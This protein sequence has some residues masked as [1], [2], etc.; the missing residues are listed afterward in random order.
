MTQISFSFETQSSA[1][2]ERATDPPI[3]SVSQLNRQIREQLEGQFSM[4][5]IRGEISNFKAHTSGHLYFSLK[6]AKAQ[7]SAIMFRGFNSKLKFRP[8]DGME[9]LVRGKVTVYEPRGS[10]QIFCEIMEPVG[11]GALQLAYEQ[12][13]AK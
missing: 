7:I 13:K 5:W 9:V 11:L 12:L 1:N 3:Y 2:K 6:D 10:Y 8:E 4:F